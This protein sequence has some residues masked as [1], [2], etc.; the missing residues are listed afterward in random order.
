MA[1]LT[2]QQL[3]GAVVVILVLLGAYNSNIGSWK[4]MERCG[5]RFL[6]SVLE[7]ENDPNSEIKQYYIT[8]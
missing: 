3:L 8:L 6:R 2:Y 7:D 5:A 4:T 1:Q